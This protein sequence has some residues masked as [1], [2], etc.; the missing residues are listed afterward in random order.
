VRDKEKTMSICV[1]CGQNEM[2]FK[3]TTK[4]LGCLE[5]GYVE[6]YRS[7]KTLGDQEAKLKAKRTALKDISEGDSPQDKHRARLKE[8]RKRKPHIARAYNRARQLQCTFS[9]SAGQREEI[10]KVYL[11]AE[12]LTRETGELHEVD[13][14]VPIKGKSVCGL[15]VPWNLEPVPKKVNRT[16]RNNFDDWSQI[17]LDII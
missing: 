14:V 2:A 17:A 4:C 1:K 9:L 5:Q 10:K 16:K 6:E 8:Y 13:H 11:Q 12:T 7:R 3:T 15:H